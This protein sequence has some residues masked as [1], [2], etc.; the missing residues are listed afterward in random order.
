LTTTT[1]A[2]PA[3]SGSETVSVE[4]LLAPTVFFFCR[5]EIIKK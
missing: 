4:E 3:T 2:F 1:A 5:T